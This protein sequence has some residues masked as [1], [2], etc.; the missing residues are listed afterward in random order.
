MKAPSEHMQEG[1]DNWVQRGVPHPS[2]M[3]SFFRALL[4][5]DLYAVL[6]ADDING[7]L[8]DDWVMFLRNELP[9]DCHGSAEKLIAW[10]EQGGLE[11]LRRAREVA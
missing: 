6:Y 3:G 1:I 7:P 5:H 8:I 9:S 4:M 2:D 11:G 10:H